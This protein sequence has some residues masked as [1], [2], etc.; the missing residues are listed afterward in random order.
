[1]HL[2]RSQVSNSPGKIRLTRGIDPY[3]HLYLP[4]PMHQ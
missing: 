3:R 4:L 1:M 2:Q